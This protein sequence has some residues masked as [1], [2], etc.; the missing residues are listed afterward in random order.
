M[1]FLNPLFLLGSLAV[2]APIVLHLVRREESQKVPLSSLMF[3]TR[4]TK[5]SWRRQKLQH[6]LLLMLR[7]AALLLLVLAFARPFF[8]SRVPVPIQSSKDKSVVILLDNSFSMRFGDRFEKAKKQA[9]QLVSGLSYGD[10][11]Q[12]VAFSDTSHV[13]NGPRAERGTL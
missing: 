8:T 7:V 2:I 5:K 13:L 3:V 10:S 6:L 4:M 9:L 12:V 1:Q 11:A